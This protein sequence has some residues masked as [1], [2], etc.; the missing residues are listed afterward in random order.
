[1]K[2]LILVC[3]HPVLFSILAVAGAVSLQALAEMMSVKKK[4]K[5]HD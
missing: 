2:I 5:D 1:M 3:D 4:D